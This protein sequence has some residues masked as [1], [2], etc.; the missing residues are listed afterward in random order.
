MADP[1]VSAD[2]TRQLNYL[3]TLQGR[4]NQRYGNFL[5]GAIAD[6]NA[7]V[8]NLQT[9]FDTVSKRYQDALT[10]GS[11]MAQDEY[12]NLYNAMSGLYTAL[13]ES[14]QKQ[15]NLEATQ[16]ANQANAIT[17]A[18]NTLAQNGETDPDF[19]KNVNTFLGYIT[20]KNATG[21]A[22]NDLD[23]TKIGAN[24][25]AGL[26]AEAAYTGGNTQSKAMAVAK[27]ISIAMSASIANSGGD[28]TKVN[29]LKKMV[30]DLVAT[31]DTGA[32]YAAMI[33]PSL[34]KASQSTVSSEILKNIKTYKSA[35]TD[36][37]NNIAKGK[38]GAA[39]KSWWLGKYKGIDSGILTDIYN[40]ETAKITPGS[41]YAKNPS[42]FVSTI[43]Q[44]NTDQAAADSFASNLISSWQ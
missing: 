17:I 44:G 22:Q 6:Y 7:D 26:F 35:A 10:R 40:L 33:S 9:N 34:A 21:A 23:L 16:L 29:T 32:Q 27:A 5:N 30:S 2:Y 11:T 25:L 36:L 37:A 39:D 13:D 4:Q 15:A 14:P 38:T 19:L 12:T 1:E 43:F 3:Y 42:T 18:Q 41:A 28:V 24:G 20:D 8:T 31:G